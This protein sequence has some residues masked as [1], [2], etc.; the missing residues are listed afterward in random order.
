MQAANA[1][2]WDREIARW[3]SLGLPSAQE[4]QV[5]L[6]QL[7]RPPGGRILDAGCG[8]GRWS[9]ALAREGYPVHGLDVS[10]QAIRLARELA[11]EH[12]LDDGA[13]SF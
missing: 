6:G 2:Y 11:R 9:V 8:S 1:E 3:R 10:P 4:T 7:G 5:L 12:A 13:V